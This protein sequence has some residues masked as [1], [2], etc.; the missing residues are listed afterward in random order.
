VIK[1]DSKKDCN[2]CNACVDLCP[3]N[4]ISLKTDQEGFWY[5]VVDE[6]NCK[7]CGLCE[8]VCPELHADDLR[9]HDFKTPICY[10]AVHKNLEVRFDSTSGGL[11]SALAEKMYKDGGYV[12]GAIYNE[13]FS[14]RHIISDD[15]KDLKKLRSSKYAQS[16]TTGLF[17]K[18]KKLLKSGEKVLVCGTPCQMAGLRGFLRKDYENLITVD[19]ACR[20]INSPTVYRKFLDYME[21]KYGSKITYLKAKSKELGWR[22]LAYKIVFENG[23]TIF[24]PKETSLYT[25]GYLKANAYS[26]PSCYDCKFKGFPRHSDITL[27]DFWGIENV[28]KSLDNDLGTSMVMLTSKKG[29]AYFDQIKQKIKCKEVEFESVLPGNGAFVSSLDPPKV[30]REQFFD[31][32][33]KYSFDEVALKY[34][35]FPK[36]NIR[37][38]VKQQIRSLLALIRTSRLR[39]VPLYQFI[40]FNFFSRNIKTNWKS[41]GFIFPTPHSV[42]DINRKA[43]VK[44]DGLFSFGVKKFTKSKLESRLL[45]DSG[46]VLEV[47]GNFSFYYGADIEVFS[48]GKLIIKGDGGSNINTTIICAEKIELGEGVQ[49]GRGV[50]IRDNNG[51]HFIARQGYKDSRPIKIGNRV[52]LGEGCTIMPGVK[53]GDGAIV[54]A[55]ALVISNVPANSIVIGA[56]AKVVDTDVIWKY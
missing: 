24:D 4:A 27:A 51:G 3:E 47:N 2:G 13:D 28:D 49:I 20:G 7:D 29:L 19:F 43:K 6:L 34:F 55:K 44:L 31:D 50:T 33:N 18:T 38:L 22:R 40:K 32:L 56:P 42:I 15:K 12:G 39:I 35:P 36:L 17:S 5:P 10:A 45:V 37:Q 8:K 14:V 52:W 53:I 16:D 21:K 26:R 54:G 41:G 1:L 30:N 23:K 11:F 46:G 25:H 48:S 9:I